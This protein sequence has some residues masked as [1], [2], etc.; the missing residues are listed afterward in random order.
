MMVCRTKCNEMYDWGFIGGEALTIG[1][2]DDQ[3]I[4]MAG[5]PAR[6]S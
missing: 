3:C 5:E 2:Q 6:P 1:R 4:N